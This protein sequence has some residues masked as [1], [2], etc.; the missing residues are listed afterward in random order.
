MKSC[1]IP[2]WTLLLILCLSCSP[3]FA[4]GI[5]DTEIAG[6]FTKK[7]STE[8]VANLQ[9][10]AKVE[11]TE[12]KAISKTV[13]V[14]IKFLKVKQIL[15][16]L[17]NSPLS[18]Y[19]VADEGSNIIAITAP[20]P[21]ID[22][23]KA[24]MNEIDIEPTRMGYQFSVVDTSSGKLKD[25]GF[26][27]TVKDFKTDPNGVYSIN[28]RNQILGFTSP[29]AAVTALH[30]LASNNVKILS[31][32]TGIVA[33]GQKL[34]LYFGTEQTIITA[35]VSGSNIPSGLSSVKTGT[36][37]SIT[38]RYIA[39]NKFELYIKG[40]VSQPVAAFSSG[41][42]VTSVLRRSFE[43]TTF[44]TDGETAFLGGLASQ[45]ENVTRSKVPILGDIPLIGW[46]FRSKHHEINNQEIS[47]IFTPR[48]IKPGEI[49][50]SAEDV[51]N[52]VISKYRC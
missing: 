34:Y 3:V 42:I 25:A 48:L 21:I 26:Q 41:N 5:L 24:K 37:I 11:I 4:E 39:P 16:L 49:L 46:L 9:T 29:Y 43:L 23:I 38:P 31:Q 7:D 20:Q 50:A 47:I 33:S 12:S 28:W 6:T 8:T 35:I 2:F 18:K 10:Q 45:I 51:I 30:Y 32:P 1:C 17:S 22:A 44:V 14:P 36:E 15:T 40:D 13:F 52:G 19:I 27:F